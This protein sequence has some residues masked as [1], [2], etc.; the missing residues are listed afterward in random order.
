MTGDLIGRLSAATTMDLVRP[1][2]TIALTDFGIA[3]GADSA[4]L[5]QPGTVLGTPSYISP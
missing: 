1:G 3:L 2:G 4:S 5:T